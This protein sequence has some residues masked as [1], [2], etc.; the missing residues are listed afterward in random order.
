MQQPLQRQTSPP[1][2]QHKPWCIQSLPPPSPPPQNN[3]PVNKEPT[4]K[5]STDNDDITDKFH[6]ENEE[7]EEF[8]EVSAFCSLNTAAQTVCGICS[9]CG[10]CS[11]YVDD[12]T[13]I[14][15]ICCNNSINNSI[16]KECFCTPSL[17]TYF[18][19][20]AAAY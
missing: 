18:L 10:F 14:K 6:S 9:I 5:F 15:S 17:I 4:T 20:L 8:C 3:D 16:K 2:L 19:K 7:Y 12:T 13:D 11:F 1:L